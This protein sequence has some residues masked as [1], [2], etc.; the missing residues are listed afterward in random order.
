[1]RSSVPCTPG[2]SHAPDELALPVQRDV[3][4]LHAGSPAPAS[5][6][7]P[8]RPAPTRPATGDGR[9]RAGAY[10][11]VSRRVGVRSAPWIRALI[12]RC[13][14]S[15]SSTPPAVRT[16]VLDQ[17]PAVDDGVPRPATGPHRSHASTGSLSAPGER[18]P[19]QRPAH[20]VADRARRRAR[21]AR[22]RARGSRPI[23]GWRSRARRAH[24]STAGPGACARAAA[25]CG[26][27][28]TATR[29]SVDAEPSHPRPTG[30]PA[31]RSSRTGAMPPPPI[32]MFEL[33]QC[34]TPVPHLP[35]RAISSAFGIDAV[36]DPR[37]V[38]P[39]PDVLEVLD[40]A[41]AVDLFGV[42]CPRR[43]P[44]PDGCAGA[45]RGARRARRSPASARGSPRTAST[46]RA[47]RAPSRPRSGSW[48]SRDQPFAVG[49]DLVVVLHHRVGR[50]AAVLLRQAHRAPR[51]MEAQPEL[52]RGRGSR[53]EIRSPPPRGCT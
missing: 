35:S 8:P 30:T 29:E 34:A 49:E 52:L 2:Q 48:C 50:Q 40:R 46:G 4:R 12:A 15:I 6:R 36:R 20:E 9:T 17:D 21:R 44:R 32:I 3:A 18:D 41:P 43:G 47:R 31:A 51:R 1:M 37:A 24:P 11:S 38:A 45:R 28:S 5:R 27:P 19:F 39:P 14:R 10:R 13:R 53:R 26:P 25:R 22:R 23:R 42:A 33:G 7:A 16:A